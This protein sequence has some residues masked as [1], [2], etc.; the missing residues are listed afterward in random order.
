MMIKLLKLVHCFWSKE[1]LLSGITPLSGMKDV[2]PI[3]F[4]KNSSDSMDPPVEL[5]GAM[6]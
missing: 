1:E 3:S 6:G 2:F 5:G 4:K